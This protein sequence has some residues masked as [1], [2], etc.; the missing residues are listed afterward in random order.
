MELCN[1]SNVWPLAL[2]LTL[3]VAMG[4][5]SDCYD[6]LDPNGNITVTFDIHR[7]TDT[8]Y[9][10]RV[11]I[12]N[13]YQYHHVDKPGWKIGWT[14]AQKEIILSMSGAFATE[15]GNCTEYRINAHCCKKDPVIED[16]MPDAQWENMTEGCCRGGLVSAYAINPDKSFSSFE[17]TVGNLDSN[18]SEQAPQNLTLL[19]PGP[20]YTCGLLKDADPTVSSAIGGRRQVQVFKTWK[21]T[22]TYSTFLANKAPVCCVSLSTF[23]NPTITPCRQCSCGCREAHQTAVSCIRQGLPLSQSGFMNSL[24]LV[25]C[26]DHMCPIQVHWHVKNNYMDHWRVKLTV[27]NYNYKRNYS[28]WN[29]VV[30]HPGFSQKATTY[31]FNSSMLPSVGF[32][33]EV[34]IFWG[35][36]YVNEELLSAGDY[37]VG[38][39]STEILLEKDLKTFTYRNGW[40]FPRKLYFNGEECEMPPPDTFPML[41]NASSSNPGPANF[42]LL[43]ILFLINLCLYPCSCTSLWHIFS[44]IPLFVA[45][46]CI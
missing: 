37:E 12:Q 36:R 39:V 4:S 11:T 5:F 45:W 18:A 17:I 22:C 1:F 29:V 41:P 23:Y 2:L 7:W 14:W 26:T 10:A 38:S 19:A 13:H 16:L 46:C 24:D 9:L 33:D 40:A 35:I 42:L 21:A 15:Q 30:Q 6:P 25:Q 32:A 34:A 27:S 3:L 8:G 43:L 31:S 20:G 44:A 28:D